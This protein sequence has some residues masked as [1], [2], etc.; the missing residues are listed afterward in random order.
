MLWRHRDDAGRRLRASAGLPYRSD[1]RRRTGAVSAPVAGGLEDMA[2]AAKHGPARLSDVSLQSMV[3]A[4]ATRRLRVCAR[5]DAAWRAARETLRP[6]VPQ[7]T[8][9]GLADTARHRGTRVAVRRPGAV[10]VPGLSVAGSASL[11]A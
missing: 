5:S 6:R 8:A 4:H 11:V 2:A 3:D 7:R 9:V 1:R 10:G